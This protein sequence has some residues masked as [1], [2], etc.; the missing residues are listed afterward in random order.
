[1]QTL[2]FYTMSADQ[3]T[4]FQGMKLSDDLNQM[5]RFAFSKLDQSVELCNE[6]MLNTCSSL[7]P[8]S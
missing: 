4:N 7:S 6:K 2:T 8:T 3:Y 5:V 1:M